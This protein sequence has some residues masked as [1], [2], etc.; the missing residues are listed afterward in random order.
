VLID[1][2]AVPFFP[3]Q[4]SDL[5]VVLKFME[6][7]RFHRNNVGGHWVV[8]Y[9]LLLWLS[10]ICRLPFDLANFDD[11]GST[12]GLTAQRIE[13]IGQTH[14]DKAGV[15]RDSAA[16]LLSRFF[17]RCVRIASLV[18]DLTVSRSDTQVLFTAFLSWCEPH[19][20][21]SSEVF[22]VF[23]QSIRPI[24]S[25]HEG[26]RLSDACKQY[27]R[28]SNLAEWTKLGLMLQRFLNWD[29]E[30]PRMPGYLRTL[31]SESKPSSYLDELG[32]HCCRQLLGPVKQVGFATSVILLC[33]L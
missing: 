29:K 11:V 21:E 31:L 25:T 3:H 23:I 5:E 9:L 19:L 16:L 26:N 22:L 33:L 6:R 13:K 7:Y 27:R 8:P 28:F 18:C 32:C 15:D 2:A 24:I 4:L 20:T 17:T 30:P 1:S 14:L 12:N 10:L